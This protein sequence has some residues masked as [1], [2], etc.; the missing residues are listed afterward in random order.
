[1]QKSPPD[2]GGADLSLPD[3]CDYSRDCNSSISALSLAT[4]SDYSGTVEGWCRLW[5]FSI[6][7]ALSFF[8]FLTLCLYFR[9]SWTKPSF[10]SCKSLRSCSN[11]ES[12]SCDIWAVFMLSRLIG[13]CLWAN[14]F[15][16]SS[17]TRR[18]APSAIFFWSYSCNSR[19]LVACWNYSRL[20]FSLRYLSLA[21]S[22]SCVSFWFYCS[23]SANL[24]T[25]YSRF[26]KCSEDA[27]FIPSLT[28]RIF[29]LFFYCFCRLSLSN[30]FI[31]VNGL[32]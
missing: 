17:I 6:S 20:V 26:F 13:S 10:S 29:S 15:S 7:S 12:R 22:K 24:W 5:I 32:K 21:F 28:S 1:M 30:W 14:N 3:V 19:S 9:T 11:L 31:G 23:M 16:V 4:S 25:Y 2:F 8:K 27:S 18:P